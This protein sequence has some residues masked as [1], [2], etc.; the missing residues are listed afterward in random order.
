MENY[1]IN[2]NNKSCILPAY[3]IEVVKKLEEID[4]R[5][6]QSSYS[7]RLEIWYNF[8]VELL[9]EEQVKNLLGGSFE[10]VDANDIHTLYVNVVDKYNEPQTKR[11][12]KSNS[13]AVKDNLKAIQSDKLIELVN[14]LSAVETLK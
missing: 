11:T 14:A 6:V 9:G 10:E 3:N 13:D 4:A 7:V 12:I 2:F 8:L 1:A 5:A